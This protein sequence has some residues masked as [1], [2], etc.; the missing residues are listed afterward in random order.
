MD[1]PIESF[2]MAK[3]CKLSV[4]ATSFCELVRDIRPQHPS[5]EYLKLSSTKMLLKIL[6]VIVF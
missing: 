5:T 3:V 6:E 2:L 1:W 4:L